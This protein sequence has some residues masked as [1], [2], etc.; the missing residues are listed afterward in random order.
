MIKL[1]V[2]VFNFILNP[3]NSR[4]I[5][6]GGFIVLLLLLIRQCD[7][8]ED[9]RRETQRIK[10][11]QIAL[12][13]TIRTYKDKWSRNVSEIRGLLLT[14]DELND[15]IEVLK[16]RAP[17]TIIESENEIKEK[18]VQIPVI[19]RDT[20][21]KN[22]N[23]VLSLNVEDEWGKSYRYVDVE[24]PYNLNYNELIYGDA[25]ITLEQ[26]IWSSAQISQDPQSGE[27]FVTIKTDYPGFES[28]KIE[29]IMIDRE[30]EG[31]L[32]LKRNHRKRWG[33]GINAGIGYTY[34]GAF[35][36]IGVGIGY[37]PKW[38]QW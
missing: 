30:N 31:F 21:L 28:T 23:S 20:V 1:I 37:T 5:L 2:N 10:N 15:T 11:N 16:N 35:P 12:T 3:K 22:Y 25:N 8:T 19:I 29:G 24:I 13:D 26:K 36:Y 38:L 27:V 7:A 17:V 4:M 6:L 9:A 34:K 33:V 14:L 32:D 18:I